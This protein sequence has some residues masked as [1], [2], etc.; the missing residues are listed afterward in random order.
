MFAL[1]GTNHFS[2]LYDYMSML[3]ILRRKYNR[4]VE[5][6]AAFSLSIVGLV[7]DIPILCHGRVESRNKD[8]KIL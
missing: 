3:N 4:K 7:V 8:V 2:M 5:I 6:Y 1:C